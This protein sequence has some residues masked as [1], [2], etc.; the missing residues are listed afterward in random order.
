MTLRSKSPFHA[1]ISVLILVNKLICMR[2]AVTELF[3]NTYMAYFD[4]TDTHKQEN[5]VLQFGLMF[6]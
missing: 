1:K 2:H 4:S 6:M 3:I 5:H